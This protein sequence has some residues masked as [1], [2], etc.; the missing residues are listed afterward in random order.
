MKSKVIRFESS[1]GHMKH[2]LF[3]SLAMA[4][5]VFALKWL[6]WKYL[7]TDNSLEIYITLIALFF[8]ALGTWIA[9]QLVPS[10]QAT[11]ANE[12]VSANLLQSPL[13]N[14]AELEKMN[15]TLREQEVLELLIMGCTNAEI[16]DKL[17]LSISTVKTHVST[18]FVKMEVKNR[19]QA[20]EKANRLKNRHRH[21]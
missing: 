10:A 2:I 13:S 3:Y 15:L 17:F 4:L 9:L 19:I 14:T 1:K 16:A 18:L 11:G 20:V 7:I 8:T 6:Q 12:K 5:L 21:Q